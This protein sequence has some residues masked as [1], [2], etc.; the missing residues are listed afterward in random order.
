MIIKMPI[1]LFDYKDMGVDFAAL[2]S[3]VASCYDEFEIDSYL[4]HKR[5]IDFLYQN[6]ILD[7]KD[8]KIDIAS[9]NLPN[10]ILKTLDSFV[11]NRKRLTAECRIKLEEKNLKIERV[12]SSPFIQTYA[13]SLEALDYRHEER[14]FKELPDRLFD[15][16]LIKIIKFIFL[17]IRKFLVFSEARLII[18]HVLVECVNG[19][20]ATNSPE[21]IHQDGMD[22][23]VSAFV[24]ESRN[25]CGAK[26][27]VYLEDKKTKI[28]QTTLKEGRGILQ[29]DKDSCLWH[30]VTA[31][32]PINEDLPAFR[33][34]IGLDIE[35]VR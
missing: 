19:D 8:Y 18:H 34:S 17:E 13:N 4:L 27:I 5:K 22:C 12:P 31:I 3:N 23:I 10:E 1:C 11:S 35:I 15:E 6:N 30:E 26:S 21:G 33:S 14:K 24:V 9:L 2:K 29:V 7:N 28:F 25:I 16:N 20:S 32:T